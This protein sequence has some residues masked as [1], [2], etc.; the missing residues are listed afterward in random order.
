MATEKVKGVSMA[1]LN[2]RQV[3]AMKKH[4]K[5]HTAKHIRAMAVA[6]RK[7]ETFTQSHKTAM[8]KAGK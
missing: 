5:H 6:M 2:K 4:S 3:T 8:K 7:G 1:G